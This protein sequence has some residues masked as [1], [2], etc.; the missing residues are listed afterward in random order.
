MLSFASL[1][2][3]GEYARSLF[4]HVRLDSFRDYPNMFKYFPHIRRQFCLLQIT[5]SSSYSPY[6]LSHFPHILRIRR[7]NEEKAEGKSSFPTLSDDFKG[8]VFLKSLF[9]DYL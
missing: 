6:V 3:L 4:L 7:N 9:F 2:I 5:L 8:T 1:G